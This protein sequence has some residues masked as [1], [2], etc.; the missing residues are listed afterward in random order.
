M[1]TESKT[2]L[3]DKLS[4]EC[5]SF[6]QFI[7]EF[8]KLEVKLA[9][10]NEELAIALIPTTVDAVE[11]EEFRQ[12]IATLETRHA[13]T[14][15]HTQSVVDENTKLAARVVELEKA[16]GHTNVKPPAGIDKRQ[17]TC[18]KCGELFWLHL[19]HFCNPSTALQHLQ[20]LERKAK[21][22]DWLNEGRLHDLSDW[23]FLFGKGE[24]VLDAIE[25]AMKK[26]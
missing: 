5:G 12:A 4:K 21:A 13:A 6:E 9:E 18:L 3:T 10:A 14:M 26:D 1:N 23:M 25:K 8:E 24:S 17:G 7:A 22:L 19:E 20:D 2:P 11:R 15:L 16:F